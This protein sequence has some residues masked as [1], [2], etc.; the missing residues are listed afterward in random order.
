MAPLARACTQEIPQLRPSMRWS[1]VVALVILSS[2]TD[3]W[4]VASFYDNACG[5]QWL[6]PL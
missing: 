1:A 4:G 3:D 2:T 5:L 6:L